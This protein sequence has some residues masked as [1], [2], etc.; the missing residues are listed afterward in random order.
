[1]APPNGRMG[2]CSK[3]ICSAYQD[4][5]KKT[6]N[7]VFEP[8]L[9]KNL[10]TVMFGSRHIPCLLDTG[11]DISAISK[12]CL[13]QVAPN[14]KIRYSNLT[15]ITGVCGEIHK[16][17]GTVTLDFKCEQFEF[18]H[19]FHVFE[20][21]HARMLVGIDFMKANNVQVRFGEMDIA[22]SRS[23]SASVVTIPTRTIEDRRT[24]IAST[25]TEV[26]VPP[27]SEIVIPVNITKFNNKSV[28]LLEPLLQLS[29]QKLSGGKSV[30]TI[31]N[32]KGVYRLLNPSSLPIF[33][34]RRSQIAKVSLVD[35]SSI[36]KL[37]EPSQASAFNINSSRS[38]T[39]AQDYKQTA[40]DLGINIDDNNLSQE[41]KDQLYNFLGR[42]RD[43]FAKDMS[44]LGQTHL[45]SHVIDQGKIL[46][47]A[48]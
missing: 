38:T 9:N 23:P 4:A 5:N 45:H 33:L 14:A 24:G 1:M 22:E 8:K 43:I 46:T 19:N 44:E 21:L 10:M 39:Q 2:I 28:V 30:V 15:N 25:T 17:L 34:K 7:V 16:V 26:I 27:H 36:S 13:N 42:N 31:N 47:G 32:G 35:D 18:R 37:Q 40:K 48:R 11:A 6:S 20:H 12:Y 3:K 41:Q 29:D